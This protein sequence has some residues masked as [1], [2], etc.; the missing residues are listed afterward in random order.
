MHIIELRALR[1]PNYWSIYRKKLVYMLL[2]IHEYEEKPTNTIPDFSERLMEAL[3]TMRIHRCSYKEEGGFFRRVKE[4]TWA[5][6]VIEHIALELQT[7]AGLRTGYG[8]TRQAHKKGLYH[9]V[10]S[11]EEEEAGLMAARS[12]VDI[13]QEIASGEHTIEEITARVHSDVSRIRKAADK[14]RLGPSTLSIVKEAER[15]GIPVIR[16]ND[17]SA[18]QLGYGIRRKR[19]EA[20]TT[21]CT[22]NVAVDLVSDKFETKQA[23]YEMGIPV[24]KGLIIQ[25]EDELQ[26]AIDFVGFPLVIKPLDASQGKGVM[27]NICHEDTALNAF[28]EAKKY[29]GKVLVEKYVT[30]RDFRALVINYKF[31]AAS[32]RVPA[33]VIGDGKCTV[34]E[35]I[36][37]E[38]MNPLRGSNHGNLLE[39]IEIDN[40]TME[41]LRQKEFTLETVLPGGT[42]CYLRSSAN[43]STGGIAIDRTD[44]VHP[45]NIYLFERIAKLVGLDIAGIDIVAEGL[46]Q[47]LALNCGGIVEVNA[48]PGFRMHLSPSFGKPRNVAK[49]VVDMLFPEGTPSRIPIIAVTGTNGKTTTTRLIAHMIQS[50]GT[51]VGFTTTDGIYVNGRLIQQGDNTGPVSAGIVLKDPTVETAVLE[52]ARGGILRSGLGFDRCDIGIVLNVSADHIGLGGIHTIEDMA[53]VKA[54]VAE[55]VHKEGYAILNADDELVYSIGDD[56]DCKIALISMQRDNPIIRRHIKR[57]GAAAV[58]EGEHVVLHNGS[59][60]YKIEKVAHIPVTF[61]GKAVFMI[62]NVLAAV[63]ACHLHGLSLEQIRSGLISF[64]PSAEKTP[65]R[66]NLVELERFSVLVDYAHNPAA[67]QSLHDFISKFENPVKT[68]IFGGTGDRRDEDLR[69]M[70]RLAAR[71][72]DRIIIKEEDF[73]RG[74][75]PGEMYNLI[76]EGIK[77]ETPDIPVQFIMKELDALNTAMTTASDN[78]LIVILADNIEE[79]HQAIE[80]SKQTVPVILN[81]FG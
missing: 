22:S 42:I 39:K 40:H 27:V 35:L 50:S 47:P 9:V 4:G 36:D 53:K 3:P 5:G 17:F 24:P 29:S 74:R 69:E 81:S 46:D 30:G 37:N 55:S 68:G 19:I 20:T 7:L 73:L 60:S 41:M 48:G 76:L 57:G 77:D 1:G 32:E 67:L 62:Q 14:C 33:H 56:L 79:I 64:V 49:N 45:E 18:V 43:L 71:I 12:A 34:R 72:F 28:R 10:F 44:E 80:K 59:K 66:M 70:G 23:L 63:L 26:D 31:A 8:R 11:Y 13:F 16:L 78:E 54:V 38:N 2:D 6:H 21:T 51:V 25:D 58:F 15:R 65:G 61:G 75:K 52:T